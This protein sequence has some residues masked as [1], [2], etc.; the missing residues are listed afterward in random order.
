MLK[1][2]IQSFLAGVPTVVVGFRDDQGVLKKVQQFK[3]LEL[4]RAVRANRDAWDPNVCLDLT[5]RVLD[6]VWEGTEDGAQYALRYTP[7]FE[8]IT[9]ERLERGTD[10][11][12]LPEE[13]RQ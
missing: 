3:T 11:S 5:K 1:F 2:W 8:C 10:K 6:A 4:P 12:F 9:L 13:Y 7:P